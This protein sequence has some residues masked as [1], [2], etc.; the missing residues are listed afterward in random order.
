MLPRGFS[1]LVAL[2]AYCSVALAAAALL[3]SSA[4][5]LLS[6]KF[7]NR[8]FAL[9]GT[10]Y[11]EELNESYL[12]ELNSDL[13]PLAIFLPSNSA[14][15]SLFVQLIQPFALVGVV[16]FA[17]RGA[18]Q[19]PSPGCNNINKGITIDLRNLASIDVDVAKNSVT[20]GAGVRWGDV[21]KKLLPLGLGVTGGRSILNGIGGL[22]LSGGLSFFSSREGFITDN[23]LNFEVALAS[24][25]V[26]NANSRENADLYKALRGGGN[27][28]GV[29]TRVTFR[30]F[31]Q[32]GFWGGSVFYFPD[33]F[34]SQVKALVAELKKPN[35]SPETHIMLSIGYS[36]SY[37]SLGGTLCL[38][39]LYYT[40]EAQKPAVLAPFA[41]IQPQIDSFNTM[42]NLTIVSAADEQ[43]S[44]STSNQRVAYMN[45]HVK[46]DVDTLNFAYQSYLDGIE[47]IKNFENITLSFTLQPYP[48]SL[49][50]KTS[51]QGGNS[52]GLSPSDGPIVSVLFLTWWTHPEDDEK[53][54][55]TLRSILDK[56]DRKAQSLGT[57]LP[58]EYMNYAHDFQDPIGSYGQ[59]NKLALQRASRKYD[60]LGLF[61]KGVPGGWKLFD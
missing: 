13:Q 56:V 18:G 51:F 25:K 39:Q 20:V 34:P 50:K 53:V 17:I 55:G 38:N 49:L 15:V 30:T 19:Q 60:P 12:S 27:N 6:G 14:D 59:Q 44:Q 32:G 58:F 33:S 3:P 36:A 2:A 16:D 35:P 41:D 11:Y 10:A 48:V 46:A 9:R 42:R 43:T 31:K 29:V 37:L 21:Y 47:P 5:D 24:G 22:A 61:Q 23:I 7:G 54:I 45:L 57:S 4:C 28:F 52:L 1:I 8:K 40:R 26:V